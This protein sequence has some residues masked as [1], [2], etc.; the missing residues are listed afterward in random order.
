M[1]VFPKKKTPRKLKVKVFSIHPWNV[2]NFITG[3]GFCDESFNVKWVRATYEHKNNGGRSLNI[4]E[5]T[6]REGNTW[7]NKWL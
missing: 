1:F 5:E 2:C 4:L 7:I 3:W 6:T